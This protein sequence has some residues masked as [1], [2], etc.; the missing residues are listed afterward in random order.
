M[1]INLDGLSVKFIYGERGSYLVLKDIDT[2]RY[3]IATILDGKW[4]D[5][6]GVQK[7]LSELGIHVGDELC[8]N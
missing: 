5:L 6:K 8:K 1:I 3:A 2:H 4:Y 7:A